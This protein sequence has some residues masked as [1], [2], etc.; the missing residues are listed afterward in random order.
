MKT[1]LQIFVSLSLIAFLYGG[2]AKEGC[3]DPTAT[4]YNSKATKNDGSC[5]YTCNAISYTGSASC[6]SG[7]IPVSDT[8]CCPMNFPYHC[9]TTNTCYASCI[10]AQSVCSYPS[11][12]TGQTGGN[13]GYICSAGSCTYVSSGATYSSLSSCQ[14]SCGSSSA[15]YNC[16]GS[17]CY[18]VSRG[19]TYSSLSACQSSCS[20]SSTGQLTVWNSNSSPC[21]SGAGSTISVY[22]DGSYVGGLSYYY[23]SNPGCGASGTITKTVSPGSHS[24]SA[25]CGTN[26]W[27]P[28]SIYV[29]A[30]GCSTFQLY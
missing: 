29:N 5:R 6:S 14:S 17:S 28:T 30:G 19:A 7:Y 26:T 13:S 11:K 3:T 22:I 1:Y 10:D 25:T 24:V 27:S 9:S 20:G 21:S 8:K 2:C 12:G 23:S 15:G 16:N 4:N 18:S